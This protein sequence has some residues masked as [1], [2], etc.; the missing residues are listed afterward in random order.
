MDKNTFLLICF[1]ITYL[2][3]KQYYILGII[4]LFL[5]IKYNIKNVDDTYR[6]PAYGSSSGFY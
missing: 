6:A 4:T 2:I 3:V 5:F 1:T